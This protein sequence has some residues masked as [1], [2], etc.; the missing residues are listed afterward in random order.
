MGAEQSQQPLDVNALDRLQR[1]ASHTQSDEGQPAKSLQ[2]QPSQPL[3][4][5]SLIS[6]VKDD[7]YGHD[8]DGKDPDS[9]QS[10]P[11]LDTLLSLAKN[12]SE[13]QN[14]LNFAKGTVAKRAICSVSETVPCPQVKKRKE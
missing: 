8:G 4:D 11:D 13:R 7:T 3:S 10:T 12:P 14:C 6:D 2:D 5:H 1:S 9:D